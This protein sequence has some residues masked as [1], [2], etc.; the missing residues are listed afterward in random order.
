M[1]FQSSSASVYPGGGGGVEVIWPGTGVSG[2]R[3][4]S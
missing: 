1:C 4:V 3:G 2:Q